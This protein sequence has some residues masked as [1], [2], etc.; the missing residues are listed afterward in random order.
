MKEMQIPAY[1]IEQYSAL[2]K[3]D[4][5][6][7]SAHPCVVRGFVEQWPAARSWLEIEQLKARF[8]AL[9]VT[10]GAP[11]FTTHRDQR[12]CQV[13]TSYGT[14]LDYI[15]QPERIAELFP[16]PWRKGS[17]EALR[18]MQ[19]PLYCGNLRLVRH[20][21]EPVLEQIRPLVPG[22]MECLNDHI[23]YYYQS[24]N[25]VWL[26]VS[27]AG[28]LTPLHQDNNAVI[29]Y[30][31]QLKGRKRA[32]LY[33]PSDRA[34]FHSAGV[35]YMDPLAP[36]DDEFPQWRR[37]QPWVATLEPGELLIWGANWAHH[38]ITEEDS[39]T[40]SF[41]IVNSTNL[42]AYARSFDWQHELGHFVRKNAAMIRTR[43]DDA[44][45]HAALDAEAEAPIGRAFMYA[46][47]QA[48]LHADPTHVGRPVR[49][50]LRRALEEA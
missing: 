3:E 20:A 33:A 10:A 7:L 40:V 6:V 25:H 49:E 21:A 34:Y 30:L 24:G 43:S 26:Y 42:D 35:G 9:P 47:L 4:P 18:N 44:R 11:Q 1:D 17:L 29:A 27:R 41:D 37:A 14:Y 19:L 36:N 38:V 28:A 13:Q 50:R 48:A 45:L 12:M 39:I 15:Q 32:L 46:T 23:P 22:G 16:E 8:G 31:A 2:L 5:D